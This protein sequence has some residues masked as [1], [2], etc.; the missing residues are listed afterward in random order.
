MRGGVQEGSGQSSK[1]WWAEGSKRWCEKALQ[2][3]AGNCCPETDQKI[4]EIHGTF[5]Q[6]AALPAPGT[7]NRS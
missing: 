2:I 5:D 1:E 3:P 7:G 4:P 6:K